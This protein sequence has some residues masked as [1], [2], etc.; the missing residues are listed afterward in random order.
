MKETGQ[1]W[2]AGTTW[3]AAASWLCVIAGQRR[4]VDTHRSRSPPR[5][6]RTNH[7]RRT[8]AVHASTTSSSTTVCPDDQD[9]SVSLYMIDKNRCDG[10]NYLMLHTLSIFVDRRIANVRSMHLVKFY[11]LL[12]KQLTIWLTAVV[13]SY[14]Y[15]IKIALKKSRIYK[16]RQ[17]MLWN[18]AGNI[19]EPRSRAQCAW[20]T[21]YTSRL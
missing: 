14:H 12:C 19:S 2:R 7:S 9:L 11:L 16:S 10:W 17:I 20:F 3:R 6:R 15:F 18:A 8:H 5:R 4:P 21:W 13:Q 1:Q